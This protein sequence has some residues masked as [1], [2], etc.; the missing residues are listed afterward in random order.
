MAATATVIFSAPAE[1]VNGH[2]E[3]TASFTPPANISGRSC[4]LKVVS[5]A[6]TFSGEEDLSDF[7]TFFVTMDLPQPFSFASINNALGQATIT[8]KRL[9]TRDSRNQVVGLYY[10]GGVQGDAGGYSN[11]SPFQYPRILVEIPDGPQYVKIGLHES[12]GTM[13]TD[14]SQLTVLCE[15]T[16][17]DSE[18][19]PVLSI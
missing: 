4:Y 8:D 10:T 6:V 14:V 9:V 17:I 7:S 5:V 11:A 12:T 2:V 16:A 19:D 13:T 1:L 15:I 3:Y 18:D